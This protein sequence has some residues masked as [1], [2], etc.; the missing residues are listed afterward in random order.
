MAAMN[1]FKLPTT[2]KSQSSL[3]TL[4]QSPISPKLRRIPSTKALPLGRLVQPTNAVSNHRLS[5]C[6]SST[7]GT[8]KRA[9]F[10]S[11][12]SSSY[13][14]NTSLLFPKRDLSSLCSSCLVFD[15][16]SGTSEGSEFEDR[17]GSPDVRIMLA[18][19]V[20]CQSSCYFA[21]ELTKAAA[22]YLGLQVGVSLELLLLNQIIETALGLGFLYSLSKYRLLSHDFI[23]FDWRD[24]FDLPWLFFAGAVLY[25]IISDVRHSALW[26]HLTYE[27][28]YKLCYPL[29]LWLPFTIPSTMR[30]FGA[31][32]ALSLPVVEE[33][34]VRSA[35]MMVLT[36]WFSLHISI[37]I[38]AGISALQ[39]P[40][41]FL[42]A[43]ILGT[44]LGF[45]SVVSRNI[46]API[47][48][49]ALWNILLILVL[50]FLKSQGYN[51]MEL[52]RA[53]DW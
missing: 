3:Y 27:I 10:T 53:M 24:I 29:V 6:H 36:K 48:I 16:E 40:C 20:A 44:V 23:R 26:L 21:K 14:T 2:A 34:V 52:A 51:V 17:W 30:D 7:A 18:T 1:V 5:P 42:K 15:N 33:N 9:G 28:P 22:P 49:H 43:F 35:I 38:S 46:L 19:V 31:V 45:S 50:I 12:S 32:V 8:L 4:K 39:C 41:K 47:T 37:Y 25:F 13:N 11:S